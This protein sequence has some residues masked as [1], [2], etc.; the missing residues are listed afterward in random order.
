M[1]IQRLK[2]VHRSNRAPSAVLWWAPPRN[3]PEVL[4]LWLRFEDEGDETLR[5]MLKRIVSRDLDQ[6]VGFPAEH[7]QCRRDDPGYL[8][9]LANYLDKNLALLTEVTDELDIYKEQLL[10]LIEKGPLDQCADFVLSVIYDFIRKK[11]LE[12]IDTWMLMIR[13][14][15]VEVAITVLTATLPVRSQ[16]RNRPAYYEVTSKLV[17]LAGKLPERVLKGLE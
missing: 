12:A 13:E 3:N 4:D 17:V 1:V 16:L 6:M 7:V 8:R 14:V 9:A 11:E 2:V 10:K 5:S 15:P